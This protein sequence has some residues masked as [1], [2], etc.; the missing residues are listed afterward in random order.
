MLAR[1][2]E[3]DRVRHRVREVEAPRI[4]RESMHRPVEAHAQSADR[5][6]R[7]VDRLGQRELGGARRQLPRGERLAHLPERDEGREEHDVARAPEIRVLVDDERRFSPLD[8]ETNGE[9]GG[10]DRA[11]SQGDIDRLANGR[12]AEHCE[13]E[14]TVERRPGV[15]ADMQ[16][17]RRLSRQAPRPIEERHQRRD[18]QLGARLFERFM[19]QARPLEEIVSAHL[20]AL[21]HLDEVDGVGDAERVLAAAERGHGCAKSDP[22][23]GDGQPSP[24]TSCPFVSIETRGSHRRPKI[25]VTT[26]N[27]PRVATGSLPSGRAGPRGALPRRAPRGDRTGGSRSAIAPS[28]AGGSCPTVACARPG[29]WESGTRAPG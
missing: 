18:G 28:A 14:V 27:R 2:L 8:A 4:E 10:D 12:R 7:A 17:D 23:G 15:Q 20:P 19:R 6:L 24:A 9:S 13:P 5:E 22:I 11:V 16:A 21:H 3:R 26:A 25:A 1:Q 29:P